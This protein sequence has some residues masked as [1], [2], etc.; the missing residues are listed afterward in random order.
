MDAIRGRLRDDCRGHFRGELLTDALSRGL[1]ATDASLFEIEPLAVAVPR[2]EEDLSFLV[3]YAADQQIALVPRGAGTGV[4]GESLG[5]GLI[6]DLSVHFR[7][8]LE[9]RAES[10]RVQ[11]GVVLRNLSEK[12]AKEGRRF[13]PNPASAPSCTIGGML[14]TNASGSNLLVH[15][16]TRDHVEALRVVWDNGAAAAIGCPSPGELHVGNGKPADANPG[17]LGSRTTDI[18]RSITALLE[19]NAELI[20][21]SRP[22]TPFNRCGYL[23][24]DVLGPRGLDLPRLLVGSEGTLAFFTEATLRTV[25][26]PAGRCAVLFG[27]ESLD[28]ALRGAELIRPLGPTACDLLDRRLLTLS[29]GQ[30]PEAAQ[31]VPASAEAVLLVEFERDSHDEARQTGLEV[32]DSLQRTERLAELALPAFDAEAIA[33]LWLVREAALPAAAALGAGRARSPLSKTSVFRPRRC[34]SFWPACKRSCS[35][36][37]RP[38]R[39]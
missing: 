23:L 27:F 8:I 14:A 28:A 35:A 18:I 17:D 21:A 36:S 20:Q 12:L 34:P 24:H 10:V 7:D 29:R 19:A 15:G 32:I 16:Y 37:R 3:H 22:R 6:V 2:D 9:V 1:Y 31:L 13:A 26:I 30:S 33:R 39:S 38:R 25:P 4:A 11:P 5:A